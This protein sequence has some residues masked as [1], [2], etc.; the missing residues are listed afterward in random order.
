LSLDRLSPNRLSLDRL[1]LD[2]FEQD[3]VRLGAPHSGNQKGSLLRHYRLPPLSRPGDA[4]FAELGIR[5]DKSLNT[6]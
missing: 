6:L 3:Q 4:T 2:R 5:K 1:S